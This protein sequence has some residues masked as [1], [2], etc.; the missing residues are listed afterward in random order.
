MVRRQHVI[1]EIRSLRQALWEIY[2]ILGYDTDGDKSPDH[3]I[4]PTL[5]KLVVDAAKEFR[6]EYDELLAQLPTQ[7]SSK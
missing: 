4:F 6:A 2:G 3:L 5:E 1:D 7:A